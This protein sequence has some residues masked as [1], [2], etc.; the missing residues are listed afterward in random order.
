M[1]T[2][3]IRNYSA[4]TTIAIL[5]ILFLTLPVSINAEETNNDDIYFG[6]IDDQPLTLNDIE[7]LISGNDQN[8]GYGL[9][10]GSEATVYDTDSGLFASQKGTIVVVNECKGHSAQNF[11][12][13]KK[14]GPCLAYGKQLKAQAPVGTYTHTAKECPKQY[15]YA[16][17]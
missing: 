12:E 9:E 8:N 10:I 3:S 5:L 15:V 11:A 16:V 13:G 17:S 7:S 4:S 1:I 14:V 2:N 6:C